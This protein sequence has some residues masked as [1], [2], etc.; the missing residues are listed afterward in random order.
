MIADRNGKRI[1]LRGG[2]MMATKWKKI[3]RYKYLYLMFLPVLIWYIIF[4]YVPIYGLVMVFQDFK[5]SKGFFGSAFVGLGNF[6]RLFEDK[7]F[8]RAF[9]NTVIISLLRVAFGCSFEIIVAL[10]L[11]EIRKRAFRKTIQTILYLPH[12][13]S[14]VIVASIFIIMLSPD[15]GII[16]PIFTMLGREVPV[17]LQEAGLFRGIL[18]STAM[19]KE[20]GFG[21]IIYVAALAGIDQELYSAAKIDGADRWKQLLHITLP[22]ISSTIAVMIILNLGQC[23]NWGFDQVYNLYNTLVY[24]TGDIL[25]TFIVRTAMSDNQFSY[26]ATIGVFRSVIAT[27]LLFTANKV[28]KKV[29]GHTIY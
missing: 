11:N 1:D 19:W 10:L 21:T 16:G 2:Q 27:V 25:D 6:A 13:L 26:A 23:L 17:P 12:F 15:R 4:H 3:L 29:M 20:V 5:M 8:W 22:G 7:Y 9:N 14:W 18:I 28:M 24:E